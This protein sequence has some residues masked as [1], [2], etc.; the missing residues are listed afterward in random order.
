MGSG[1]LRA[2]AAPAGPISPTDHKLKE[3]LRIKG[4]DG[5]SKAYTADIVA[6]CGE[7]E[8]GDAGG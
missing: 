3:H 8:A 2:G 7:P 1:L 4:G 6:D 5:I